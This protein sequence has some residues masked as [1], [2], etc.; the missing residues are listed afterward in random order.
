MCSARDKKLCNLRKE[1]K[2]TNK[3]YPSDPI[4]PRLYGIIKAHKPEKNVPMRVIVSTIGTLP[5]GILK[6]LVDIIQPTLNK[7]QQKVKNPKS[8]VSQAQTWK[9]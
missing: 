7:N 2:F 4:P 1:N 9:I 6:Y 5:Y 8:F 3:T